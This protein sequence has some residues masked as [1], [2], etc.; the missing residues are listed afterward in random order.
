MVDVSEGKAPRTKRVQSVLRTIEILRA[1][2][3][4]GEDL[5]LADLAER[6]GLPRSTVHRIVQTLQ[7]AHFV[8]KGAG[9]GGLRLGLGVRPS[10]REF[11]AGAHSHGASLP[12]EARSRDLRGHEPH[13]SRR[14]QRAVSRPG[15]RR[16]RAAR[17][18]TR[19]HDFPCALHCEWKDPAGRSTAGG[20][21]RKGC[22]NG[23][24]P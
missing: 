17:R 19:R 9:V 21:P 3:N 7:S 18:H 20:S 11:P 8:A 2:G 6:T 10:R 24:N 1:L 22:L 5:T 23:W 15:D 12:R 4:A 16:S 14:A 13:R